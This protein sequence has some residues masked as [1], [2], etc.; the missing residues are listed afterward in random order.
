MR[1]VLPLLA[2]AACAGPPVGGEARILPEAPTTL[3]DLVVEV[4]ADATVANDRLPL[5]Y[6][7]SWWR[8]GERQDDA[9]TDTLRA[10]RTARG[11]EWSV[12][13]LPFDGKRYGTPII[14]TVTIGNALPAARVTI[15][16]MTPN[17]ATELVATASATDA[18]DDEVTFT[19]AWRRDGAPVQGITGPTVAPNFTR[20]GQVWEVTAIPSDGEGQ[21]TAATAE[22]TIRNSP[23]SAPEVVVLPESPRASD[24]LR[25]VVAE[26]S[27]DAD[28]D[29]IE[30]AITW[31]RNGAA[32]TGA[33]TSTEYAGDTVLA[34]NTARDEV[35]TCTAT[36][37]D[38]DVAGT[39]A[40]SAAVTIIQPEPVLLGELC[41]ATRPYF[42]GGNCTSNTA[43]FA[44]AYCRIGGFERASSYVTHT[45][46]VV[47]NVHY[48]NWTD[49]G[50]MT[51]VPTSC[52]QI[53][54]SS[55]YGTATNCTCVSQLKCV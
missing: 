14:A 28:G 13:L 27:V 30:Y 46:G 45:T 4:L 8:D 38:G 50:S 36:P 44:D 31:T 53:R 32:W 19:W 41:G 48:Y 11:E 54:Y 10:D 37:S 12:Q 18:D 20:R 52:S 43:A 1:R 16:P 42:C 7:Y 21:G 25:C 34:A 22:V 17:S 5:S 3:D 51:A 35:W 39:S 23:P 9:D 33:T 29:P 49:L 24:D 40:T 15:A 6:E 2:L 55:S 47:Y 26:E